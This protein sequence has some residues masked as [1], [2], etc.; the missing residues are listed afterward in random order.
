M[1]ER[2]EL[3][4]AEQYNDICMEML[5]F[6]ESNNRLTYEEE[7]TVV[8]D[9]SFNLVEAEAESTEQINSL[10]AQEQKGGLV[11]TVKNIFRS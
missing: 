3:L 8:E 9:K 11:E 2:P 4:T 7:K 5:K 1:K 6:Q 10:V